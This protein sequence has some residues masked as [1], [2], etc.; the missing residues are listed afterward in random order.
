VSVAT[1]IP[2]VEKRQADR[3]RVLR[4]IWDATN[5]NPSEVARTAPTIQ[6]QL[7]LSDQELEAACDYLVG[8]GL[9]RPTSKINE[10]PGY[11]AVQ[12]THRGVREME[13]SISVPDKPTEHL[14]PAIS[15]VHIQGDVIGSPIQSGSPGA[16]QGTTVRD[17]SS[18]P[19]TEKT[20]AS[21]SKKAHPRRLIL[22]IA[23]AGLGAAVTTI[24]GL[25]RLYWWSLA[26]VVFA[27]GAALAAVTYAITEE[28]EKY[29]ILALWIS[30][31]LFAVLL[32]TAVIY[33]FIGP[34]PARTANVVTN[35]RVDLSAE[36]GVSAAREP[37]TDIDGQP[38]G[39]NAG[40][41]VTA[42]CYSLAGGSVWLYFR[43]S[44]GNAGFAPLSDFHY[45]RGFTAQLPSQC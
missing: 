33:E 29:R 14:P 43:T 45:Q 1:D 36:A 23:V 42:T 7:G 22:L 40:E 32:L 2:H 24:L 15:V 26:L 16:Q 27:V 44:S 12:L 20:P 6:K 35:Q 39:F 34:S 10:S 37:V 41:A 30:N 19:A 13:E 3:L 18:E 21:E 17:I 8:E 28:E 11:I 25:S 38:E 5:G 9:I 31:G 4:A